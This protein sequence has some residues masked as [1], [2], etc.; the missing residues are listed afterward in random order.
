MFLKIPLLVN[1]I[2]IVPMIIW[3]PVSHEKISTGIAGCFLHAR[4]RNFK[5][6]MDEIMPDKNN[7]AYD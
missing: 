5:K 4:G 3:N 1:V 7:H 2:Y 6:G